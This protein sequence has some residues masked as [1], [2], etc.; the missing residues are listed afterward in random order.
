MSEPNSK[1]GIIQDHLLSELGNRDLFAAAGEYARDYLGTL[2]GRRVFPDAAALAAL[3][4]FDAPLP[5]E[6]DAGCEILNRLHSL[7]SP[8]TVTSAGG[9]YFGF[10]NGGALPVAQAAGWLAGAWD[11]NAALAVM[12]PVSAKLEEVCEKWLVDL[13]G[14][15][16]GTVAGF[17]S[18][19]SLASVCGIAAARN[20]ILQSRGWDVNAK[21]L[22]GAPDVRVVVGASAHATIFKALA[23]LGLGRERVEAVPVDGEGRMIAAEMP[24]LDANCIVLAQAGNV[25]SGSFDPLD[26]IGA[27][28]R[29]AGAW[30]HVDGAF[31]MWAAASRATRELTQGIELA[32]SWSVDAHKTLNA[33]YDCG[34]ILCRHRDALAGALQAT[35]SYIVYGAERD[36]M[37]FTP[38]MSRR[39]RA[40]ELW[41][42]LSS[43][44][45]RGIEELIDGLCG[46]A[47]GFAAG[48][49]DQGFHVRNDVV[50]NQVLVACDSPEETEAVLAHIQQSGECW[51][52]GAT[53]QGQPVI[54]ISVC[55]WATTAADV[56]RSI[57]AFVAARQATSG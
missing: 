40:I 8:A 49:A 46:H 23:L 57:E 10:V 27:R 53:W 52:G 24:A 15:P 56:Q 26:E 13:F 31:G 30:V 38:E 35:G 42:T 54:R 4:D 45:R 1:V 55:S 20:Q 3:Q 43:L 22:F 16:E 21:G 32:D 51:C 25:N 7:G 34:V 5:E 33:P 29:P 36:G 17:V 11:Q 2:L 50:F 19:T 37:L 12:S 48:L 28:A 41:A 44:G 14:L 39:A 9:R 47:R 18:G 6:P